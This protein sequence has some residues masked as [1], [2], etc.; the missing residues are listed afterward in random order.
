[1]GQ[2]VGEF[3]DFGDFDY[4]K[5]GGR[6]ERYVFSSELHLQRWDNV[7]CEFDDLGDF[8]YIMSGGQAERYI[9]SSFIK[10]VAQ[11]KY[12]LYN[13]CCQRGKQKAILIYIFPLLFIS[14]AL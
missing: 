6:A 11:A 1:M 8:C 12:F 7:F 10:R 4:I 3:D 14:F 5:S 13:A 9:F 2:R